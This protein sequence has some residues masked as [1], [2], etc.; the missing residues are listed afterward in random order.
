V[1]RIVLFA[2]L[3]GAALVLFFKNIR[4]QSVPWRRLA[5]WALAALFG[6]ALVTLNS[7]PNILANY[8]TAI[9]LRTFEAIT[10]VSLF[11]AVLFGFSSAFFLLGLAWFF[12]ARAFGEEKLNGWRGL[13]ASYYRDALIVGVGGTA[14]LA[15]L[16]RLAQVVSRAWP[17]LT[18]SLSA[19]VPSHLDGYVPAG[20]AVGSA[21]SAGLLLTA[22][23]GLAT[24]FI[25]CHLQ[26]RWMR[27]ALLLGAAAAL[28][29]DWGSP[30]DF[31]KRLLIEIVLL[32][33]VWL[34]VWKVVRFNL[35]AYFLL[36]ALP[37]LVLSAAELLQQPNTFFRAN[38][39]VAAGAA[40][41]LLAW[42]L[43]AWQTAAP[44]RPA[45]A[46]AAGD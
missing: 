11:V 23:V 2:G 34:G 33:V 30:A 17:T 42:P 44:E 10:G 13:P 6:T 9:P 22:T 36:A 40:I 32:G 29:G 28:V 18:R 8:P 19:A 14:A 3:G 27:L 5:I 35:P 4:Q 24:G 16:E 45:S 39:W 21:L 25:A 12:L 15:G 46:A 38:G 26:Q 31:V 41:V 7:L 37:G 1:W 20:N 43:V